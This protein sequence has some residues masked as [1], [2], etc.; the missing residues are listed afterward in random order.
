[1]PTSIPF[2]DITDTTVTGAGYF[3]QM[4]RSA[5]GHLEQEYNKNRINK[6]DYAEVYLGMMKSVL[7]ESI[8][9]ALGKAKTEAETDKVLKDIEL[10]EAQRQLL[11][12]EEAK[13]REEIL[14]IT[15]RTAQ[16]YKT[17]EDIS[18]NIEVK[19]KDMEFK[20]KQMWLMDKDG[21]I[22]DQE[23][24]V[25]IQKVI[26]SQHENALIL[27]QIEKLDVDI[28]KELK[29]VE[30]ITQDILYLQAKIIKMQKDSLLVDKQIELMSEEILKAKQEVLLMQQRILLM[31]AEIIKMQNEATLTAQR[32]LLIQAQI[33]KTIKDGNLVDK[34][35]LLAIE[36]IKLIQAQIDK[37]LS[38]AE[39]IAQQVLTEK[40]NTKLVRCRVEECGKKVI[41][42]ADE[43]DQN[44]IRLVG[45]ALNNDGIL[46]KTNMDIERKNLLIQQANAEKAKYLNTA[47]PKSVM[48]SQS[49][50]LRNQG[51]SYKAD[52]IKSAASFHKDMFSVSRTQNITGVS[53]VNANQA[54]NKINELTAA[55]AFFEA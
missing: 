55:A 29:E 48:G 16:T 27:K 54:I 18:K 52:T 11:L 13:C 50:L 45:L 53:Y 40:E 1:M 35:I 26:H 23:L 38:D 24:L 42:L 28:I 9:F 22:K 41:L 2:I 3:D 7:G 46:A 31:Q 47:H 20:D 10:T 6:N 5:K 17:I 21:L 4:M 15:A 8:R 12:C 37:M 34:E 51:T 36:K 39:L 25:M 49:R 32:I 30:Y 33:A 19:N 14:G 44:L 43:H